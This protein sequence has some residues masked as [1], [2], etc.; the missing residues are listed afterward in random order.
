MRTNLPLKLETGERVSHLPEADVTSTGS[1]EHA[2]ETSS[3][4]DAPHVAAEGLHNVG[5]KISL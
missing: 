5:Q 3:K 2:L 4:G 1:R